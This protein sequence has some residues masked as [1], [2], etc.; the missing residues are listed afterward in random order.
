MRL[1]TAAATAAIMFVFAAPS[2]SA[3]IYKDY[4]PSKEVYDV[5]FVHVSPNR[6]DDYLDGLKQTWW[7]SCQAQ[8]KHGAAIDCQIYS[9]TT[10]GNRDFNVILVVKRPS[11]AM[12]DPDE[13]RYNAVMAD[14]RKELAEDKQ[15]SLV[16]GYN[17]MRTIFGQ[18]E[19]RQLTFK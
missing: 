7:G 1:T 2:H 16:E 6:L 9:S 19:F 10:M 13:A 4:V 15:K 11:A 14:L 12:S 17:E 3:K 8:K 18:E 5:T